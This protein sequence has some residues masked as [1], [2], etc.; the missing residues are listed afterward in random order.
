MSAGFDNGQRGLGEAAAL[1]TL[2]AKTEFAPEF[3]RAKSAFGGVVRGFDAFVVEER[4]E[5]LA[6]LQQFLSGARGLGVTTAQAAEQQPFDLGAH[7]GQHS[8]QTG[9][10][11]R[12]IAMGMPLLE[13]PLRLL[14]QVFPVYPARSLSW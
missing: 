9:V 4:L 14:Q 13:Q 2:G 1:S 7:G 3:R 12:V 6:V 5:P 11:Q 10:G 8:F